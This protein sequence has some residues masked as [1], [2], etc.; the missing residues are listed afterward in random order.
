[1]RERVLL[2]ATPLLLVRCHRCQH[3]G[4]RFPWDPGAARDWVAA[5]R[6][7]LRSWPRG[8]GRALGVA[9]VALVLLGAGIALVR[10]RH[11][12]T[13]RQG[14]ADALAA[15]RGWLAAAPERLSGVIGSDPAPPAAAAPEPKGASAAA[16][17]PA[18]DGRPKAKA[19]P[20]GEARPRPLPAPDADGWR[21]AR[22]G[23]S[24]QEVL[25]LLPAGT[26]TVRGRG[27]ARRGALVAART[28]ARIGER[29]YAVELR[30]DRAGRLA[31]IQ[32]APLGDAGDP[33]AAY[34]EVVAWLSAENG[35]P[36]I[37]EA[38]SSE[39]GS[40]QRSAAWAAGESRIDLRAWDTALKDARILRFDLGSGNI[41]P[42]QHRG[43][44]LTY[45]PAPGAGPR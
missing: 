12:Q 3:R 7:A 15:G 34:Q 37:E 32:M 13:L 28:S 22:W 29:S 40:W 24:A 31:A 18:T 45:A 16:R 33:S 5:A 10:S 21:R 26:T 35:A 8:R 14:G 39:A 38:S 19:P 41:L 20:R 1:V 4:W 27:G 30:F 2:A 43:L 17:S 9:V 11:A 25:D 23:M 36:S 42:A 6:R 44:V